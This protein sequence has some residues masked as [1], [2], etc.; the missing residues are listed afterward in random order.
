MDA[1]RDTPV[2]SAA[3]CRSAPSGSANPS[4]PTVAAACYPS[5]R[6]SPG[7]RATANSSGR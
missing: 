6:W 5:W 3:R 7:T 4:A 2:V 1:G